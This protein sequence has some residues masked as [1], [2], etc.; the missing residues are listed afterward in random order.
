MLNLQRKR[1]NK[2]SKTHI[3]STNPSCDSMNDDLT[4]TA[5]YR[6]TKRITVLPLLKSLSEFICGACIRSL[7][8]GI[9]II[10]YEA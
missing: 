4:G 7:V 10:L 3:D 1:K 2:S 6:I 9:R 8:E 5:E